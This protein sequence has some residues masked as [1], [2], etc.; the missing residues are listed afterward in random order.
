MRFIASLSFSTGGRFDSDKDDAEV[1]GALR[2][3]QSRGAVIRAITSRLAG[4]EMGSTLIHVI[5]YEAEAP[6][7]VEG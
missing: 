2:A 3:R 4:R 6:I 1:N 5:E 7:G